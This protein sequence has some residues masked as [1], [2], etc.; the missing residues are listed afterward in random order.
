MVVIIKNV[1]P[2]QAQQHFT[3]LKLT[4]IIQQ[5]EGRKLEFKQSLPIKAE[6][7]KTVIAFAYDA[8]GS[9]YIGIKNTPRIIAGLP[10][11][12]LIEAEEQ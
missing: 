10:E 8:G 1:V 5:Q 12:K 2:L 7:A 4:E 9:V 3:T 6:L 11:D